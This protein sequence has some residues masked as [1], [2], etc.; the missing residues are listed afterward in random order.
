MFYTMCLC[1]IQER[2]VIIITKVYKVYKC[3]KIKYDEIPME[4]TTW[5]KKSY[6]KCVINE[7]CI[8]TINLSAKSTNLNATNEFEC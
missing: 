3:K 8:L 2:L 5:K 7:K 4:K 1:A 6:N